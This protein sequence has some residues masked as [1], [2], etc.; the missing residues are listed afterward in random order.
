MK[1]K[2]TCILHSL[3]WVVVFLLF[4]IC[5]SPLILVFNLDYTSTL[6]VQGGF[7]ALS[8][9]PVFILVHLKRYKW[10]QIGFGKF[11][12]DTSKKKLFL[13][14]LILIYI[15]V[16]I[17]GFY[18]RSV[19]YFLGN[20]FLYL[21][22]AISE[23]LYFRGIIPH[24]LSKKFSYHVSMIISVIIFGL[25]HTFLSFSSP[26]MITLIL[27]ILTSLI[28]AWFVIEI[29]ALCGNIVPAI[30]VHFIFDFECKIVAMDDNMLLATQIVR[31][32]IMFIFSVI[33]SILGAKK[34]KDAKTNE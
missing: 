3:L 21:F 30:I 22:V 2:F 29:T 23:E 18:L 9:V 17:K 26:N 14:S 28:F 34:N 20:L 33:F 13:V 15:P 16:A 1:N 5:A 27:N 10:Q 19:P 6:F 31:I 24:I 7:I 32:G 12:L 25:A 8:L 11:S 4:P